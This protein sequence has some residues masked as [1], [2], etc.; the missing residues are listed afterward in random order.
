V[1]RPDLHHLGSI[2]ALTVPAA[3]VLLP[4]SG[5]RR[6]V[7]L[8]LVALALAPR[9]AERAWLATHVLREGLIVWERPRAEILLT[10]DRIHN[11]ERVVGTWVGTTEP[12]LIWPAH[13]GLHFVFGIPAPTRHLLMPSTERAS[14]EAIGDLSADPPSRI[15]LGLAGAGS[16]MQIRRQSPAIWDFLRARYEVVGDVAGVSDEFRALQWHEGKLDAVGLPQRLPDLALSFANDSSPA[17]VPDLAVGQTLVTGGSDL[18]GVS[19]RWA[20]P[21]TDL[22]PRLRIDVWAQGS[23]GRGFTRLLAFYDIQLDIPRDGHRSWIRF[24]PVADTAQREL[25]LT[26]ELQ[27]PS[28]VPLHLLWHRHDMGDA[29]RDF[30]PEGTAIVNGQPVAADLYLSTY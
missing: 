21:G 6:I 23:D 15:L 27:E 5:R 25:A 7:W 16:A 14:L 18:A 13:P 29:E 20:T 17:L 28:P 19:L 11:L 3:L 12:A 24:G 22:H 2:A 9:A 26:F 30:Y 1:A 4:S 8:V 10:R